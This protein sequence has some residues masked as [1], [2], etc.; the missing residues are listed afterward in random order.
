[1]DKHERC[2]FV[3]DDLPIGTWCDEHAGTP[4]TPSE[5]VPRPRSTSPGPRPDG[6]RN[7]LRRIAADSFVDFRGRPVGAQRGPTRWPEEAGPRASVP[8][9]SAPR[10]DSA[11]TSTNATQIREKQTCCCGRKGSPISVMASRS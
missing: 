9:G 11:A 8:V 7:D 2:G 5:G 4:E 6:S 10:T 3:E 1:M